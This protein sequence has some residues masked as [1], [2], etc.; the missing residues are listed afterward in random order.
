MIL[1]PVVI[2]CGGFG[3]RLRPLTDHRPKSLVEVAGKPF[4]YH[5]LDLL[6]S[7]GITDVVLCIGHLGHAIQGAVALG[8]KFGLNVR[9]SHDGPKPLGTA[10]AIRKALPLLDYKFFVLYAD[11]LVN[12]N[13]IG[14]ENAIL[15][16]MAVYEKAGKGNV[17]VNPLNGRI[18]YNKAV[19]N[20]HY[21][22]AGL[23]LLHAYDLS[24][25]ENDLADILKRL[26]EANLMGAAYIAR[27][28][29]EIGSH[30]G[31]AETEAYLKGKQNDKETN[32]NH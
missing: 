28:P 19:R 18:R 24:G 7:Q 20:C 8:D 15:S 12:E 21:S 3:T 17:C 9:Y 26:S 22:D 14:W 4:I 25:S 32:S 29:L 30:Q 23:M 31:L 1:P 5:Q 6:K 2:L 11:V 10:G 27:P 16:F 13:M